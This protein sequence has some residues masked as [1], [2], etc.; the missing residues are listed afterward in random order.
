M[1]DEGIGIPCKS[2]WRI[3]IIVSGNR[4]PGCWAC[5]KKI[6]GARKV[7]E[8][9]PQIDLREKFVTISSPISTAIKCLGFGVEE[10]AVKPDSS[11]YSQSSVA[12]SEIVQGATW[13]K[14]KIQ[15][16]FV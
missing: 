6:V 10:L 9:L 1:E 7:V 11:G 14:I 15:A 5:S 3:A 2:F 13:S 8:N 12:I 4:V 16:S